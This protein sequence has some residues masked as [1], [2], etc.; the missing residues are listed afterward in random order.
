M[1]TIR[2]RVIDGKMAAGTGDALLSCPTDA[3]WREYCKSVAQG[4]D[5]GQVWSGVEASLDAL[6]D[7]KRKLIYDR[8]D[9]RRELEAGKRKKATGALDGVIQDF[10][11]LGRREDAKFNQALN[12][13][14]R[15]FWDKRLGR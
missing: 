10:D 5:L 14:R 3:E 12:D 8:L 15:E 13:Q 9:A 4:V 7:D 1:K 6:D 2:L 11:P